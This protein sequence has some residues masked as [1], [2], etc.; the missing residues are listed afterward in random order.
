MTVVV[1]SHSYAPRIYYHHRIIKLPQRPRHDCLK[2]L[3]HLPQYIAMRTLHQAYPLI[4]KL[5]KRKRTQLPFLLSSLLTPLVNDQ[6]KTLPPLKSL[7]GLLHCLKGVGDLNTSSKKTPN[8]QQFNPRKTWC[9]CDNPLKIL[10]CVC[11][12]SNSYS[13]PVVV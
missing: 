8:P 13:R 9:V 10:Q 1:D 7:T 2:E 4:V 12:L 11:E 6:I 5:I 3:P